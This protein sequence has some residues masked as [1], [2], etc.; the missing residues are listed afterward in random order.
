M[1]L[2][3]MLLPHVEGSLHVLGQCHV[4]MSQ[5]PL[6]VSPGFLLLDAHL[7]FRAVVSK[8]RR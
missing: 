1:I 8:V 5:L 7:L 3:V 6:A 2:F 4:L